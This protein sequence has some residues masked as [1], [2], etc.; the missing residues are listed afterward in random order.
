MTRKETL[1]M[2]RV[3]AWAAACRPEEKYS[4]LLPSTVAFLWQ[5]LGRKWSSKQLFFA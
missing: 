5:P 4:C 2:S 1:P 3:A